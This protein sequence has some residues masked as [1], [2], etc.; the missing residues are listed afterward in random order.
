MA[1]S[2]WSDGSIGIH[3]SGC[4]CRCGFCGKDPKSLVGDLLGVLETVSPELRKN[5]DRQQALHGLDIRND[6]AAPLGGEFAFAIDGP[7][8]PTPSWKMVLEVYDQAKLQNTFERAV[9]KI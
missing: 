4:Q 5:L 3:L 1:G 2:A 7:I 8:L 6:I 9:A